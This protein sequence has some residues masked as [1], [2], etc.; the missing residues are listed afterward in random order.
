MQAIHSPESVVSDFPETADIETA[1]ED[2]AKRFAGAVGQW[3]LQVQE[4][5]TIGMLQSFTCP[6]I[7][8]VGGGHGQLT[9]AFLKQ[10]ST[11]TVVGSAESCKSRIERFLTDVH[12][13]FLIG[14]LIDLP[15]PAQHFDVSVS[16]RLL[17]HCDAWK[18][19]ISELC[20]VAKYAVIVDYP[21]IKSINAIAPLLFQWKKGIEKNTRPFTCF[22]QEELVHEFGRHGFMLE[23]RYPEFCLPMVLHR[24][25]KWPRLSACLEQ[26]LRFIGLTAHVGSPVILKFVRHS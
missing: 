20:R 10:G 15:F 3:F 21:D 9:D 5:A 22:R 14:N 25:L 8:D 18:K 2:Y 19:L 7:I 12:C 11:I 23:T 16:F 1:S 6:S 4:E 24:A 26:F 13:R 17:P